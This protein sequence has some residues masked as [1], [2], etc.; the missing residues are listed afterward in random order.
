[1][2]K[3]NIFVSVFQAFCKICFNFFQ[4]IEIGSGKGLTPEHSAYDLQTLSTLVYPDVRYNGF[5]PLLP[6]APLNYC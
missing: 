4:N 2:R 5:E 6:L 1:M 3:C